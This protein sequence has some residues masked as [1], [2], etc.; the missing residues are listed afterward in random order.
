MDFISADEKL[1]KAEL[2]INTF[3]R[4][5]YLSRTN[6]KVGCDVKTTEELAKGS[7]FKLPLKIKGKMLGEGRHKI[8]FY[9]KQEL[10]KATKNPA[11]KKFPLKV[12]HRKDEVA[13]I[14]G[15]VDDIYWDDI[16]NCI[17]YIAHI[18][19]ETQA[20]NAVDGLITDVSVNIDAINYVDEQL[21]LC[22]KDLDFLEL[23]FVVDGAYEGNTVEVI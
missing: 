3:L 17:R 11:N 5:E 15:G 1:V 16:D 23:S 2:C 22:G 6:E 18:N 10:L 9:N 12:D 7:K 20:R 14:I 21:G 4:N 8:R 13:S 19:D